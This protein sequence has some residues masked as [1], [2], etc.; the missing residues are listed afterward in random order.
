MRL[1]TKLSLGIGFLFIVI[2]IF[3]I[4]GIVSINQL[5]TDAQLILKDNY[6]TL[7][8]SNNMLKALE[9][10]AY[11]STFRR[12]FETNLVK[13][14]GNITE[15]GEKEATAAIRRSF[16]AVLLNGPSDS[17]KADIR[18]NIQQISDLNQQAI[19]KKNVKA[20]STA[21]T[22][23]NWLLI[24]FSILALISFTLAV[25]FPSVI[26]EPVKALSEGIGAIVKKDYGI[27]IHLKQKDE[28]GELADNFNI[29]A[30]KLDEYE[31]SNL[32]K[33]KFEKTRI[34]T[35]I[36]QMK[37]GIIGL[38]EKRNILFI[39]EVGQNL[40]GLQEREIA[41]KYVADIA[42]NNDL[43]RTL[44]K[45]DTQK[46]LKIYADGKE[47]YFNKEVLKVMNG[48]LAAG[49]VI[50]LRNITPFHELN[51]AKTNFI[52]TVSH[53]LKTP[54]SSIKMSLQLL[55][56]QDTGI[57]NA[58][59]KQLIDS[60]K[61]DSGRLLKITGELL[62]LS[63]V[64]TG[65]IQLTIQQSDPYSILNYALEAVKVVAEQKRVVLKITADEHLPCV[66]ADPEKTAWVLINLLTNA[67]RYSPEDKEVEIEVKKKEQHILFAVKDA[68]KGIE[69]RYMDK[70][71][72][73]YF[74]VP[75]S[76]RS[77]TGLGLSISKEFIEAQGGSI[78]LES[79]VGTGS[80][81]YFELST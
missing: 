70:I 67:I 31:H 29:M 40:L 78:G 11:D 15:G 4:L 2:L 58:E 73:R 18:K 7:V 51:E 75:G 76:S 69:A 47:S 71:F 53:E 81:F 54:I 38:D 56:K 59:Q 68:G 33:I 72:T 80:R 50:I 52:A 35:I 36:N 27:R 19:F 6:E 79:E 63:Q 64:E 62:N 43:M 77:G 26:S 37:D 34:E 30:E 17:L 65:N 21:E 55:E 57:I 42:V 14:E 32:A 49:E 8:Y 23:A 10:Q 22:A 25:N 3:G 16:N 44:L 12:A 13:Q 46:D 60:I 9:S 5:K 41:G 20:E 1:K 28:F 24:T 74:Q 61:E 48:D 45:E 66:K 39:N